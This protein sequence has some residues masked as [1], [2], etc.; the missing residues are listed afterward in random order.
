MAKSSFFLA[1]AF[2]P[3]VASSCDESITPSTPQ[4]YG[5]WI[6]FQRINGTT[7]QP[8]LYDSTVTI[9]T[10][11]GDD[12]IVRHFANDSLI[13]ANPFAL[14]RR[15]HQGKNV[16]VVVLQSVAGPLAKIIW[17][18]DS[19]SLFLE[20]LFDTFDKWYYSKR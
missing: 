9:K 15:T 6:L 4:I 17:R 14:S 20:D 10:A 1:L 5:T 2:F 3:L 18:A 8:V 13:G 16:D 11:F 19:D 12:N 7:G